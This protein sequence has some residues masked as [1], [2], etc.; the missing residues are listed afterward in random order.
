[1][2]DSTS[3]VSMYCPPSPRSRAM[4]AARM[5]SVAARQP[6]YLDHVRPEVAKNHGRVRAGQHP[7]EV[8]DGNAAEWQRHVR[9]SISITVIVKRYGRL[10]QVRPWPQTAL[11]SATRLIAAARFSEYVPA[12]SAAWIVSTHQARLF[13]HSQAVTGCP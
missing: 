13:S 1:M 11:R 5:A 12:G 6:F 3:D 8:E 9:S 4:Y 7:G 10:R 2:P